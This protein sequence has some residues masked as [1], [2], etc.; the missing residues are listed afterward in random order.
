MSSAATA[1]TSNFFTGNG[2]ASSGSFS[3]C[4]FKGATVSSFLDGAIASSSVDASLRDYGG[5]EVDN[6]GDAVV[7][8]AP[9]SSLGVTVVLDLIALSMIVFVWDSLLILSDSDLTGLTTTFLLLAFF[10]SN[11]DCEAVYSVYEAPSLRLAVER[12][13]SDPATSAG[14]RG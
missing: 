13:G 6:S 1:A 3:S 4:F 14:C 11:Y 8:S 12:S 7:E 5:V 10:Y 2:A 9:S